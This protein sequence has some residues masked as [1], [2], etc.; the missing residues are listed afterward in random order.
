MAARGLA[1][2]LALAAPAAALL[3][4]NGTQQQAN[5]CLRK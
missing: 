2:P 3:I 4:K 5:K 1:V